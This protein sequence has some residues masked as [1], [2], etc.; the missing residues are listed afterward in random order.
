VLLSFAQFEREVTAERIRDKIAASKRKGL[1]MGGLVPF[2]FD[3]EGRTLKVRE[4]EAVVVR[5]LFALYARLGSGRA[6]HQEATRLGF[7]SRLRVLANDKTVGGGAFSRGHIH[8]MLSN[9]IYVGRIRHKH[10]VHDGLH[11]AIVSSRLWD[12]VQAMLANQARRDRGQ[13]NAAQPS[14][15]AGKLFD[16][17]GD[18]LTPSHSNKKGIR[19]RYYV[20]YRLVRQSGVLDPSGW[21]LPARPLE[22]AIAAI[23]G[24]AFGETDFL[25]RIVA[26]LSVAE[27]MRLRDCVAALAKVVT[28]GDDVGFHRTSGFVSKVTVAP[29]SIAISIDGAALSSAIGFTPDRIAEENL[30]LRRSLRLRR[31]GVETRLVLGEPRPEIDGTLIRNIARA[32]CWLESVQ[33]GQSFDE[34]AAQESVSKNRLQQMIH[35]A[36]LAPDIVADVVA[37]KPPLGLTSEWLKGRDLP[38]SWDAQ[39]RLIAA[40]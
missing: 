31:R 21:R 28:A 9:P 34:I 23:L 19:Y 27:M 10:L 14:P 38:V 16:E 22:Q 17:T 26:D 2:G 7:R 39:R 1:W 12:E 5:E 30:V 24:E 36:F 3:A 8:Q 35:L 40:L 11:P 4:G 33:R 20:S 37:G 18:R 25:T 13:V 32:H 6:V 29:D 15:F